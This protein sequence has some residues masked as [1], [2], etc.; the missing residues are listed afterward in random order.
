MLQHML[1]K[2]GHLFGI[3]PLVFFQMRLHLWEGAVS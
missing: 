2:G 3:L 1:G